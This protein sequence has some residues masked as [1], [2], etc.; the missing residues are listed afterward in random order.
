MTTNLRRIALTLTI[1]SPLAIAIA[2][3]SAADEAARENNSNECRNVPSYSELKEALTAARLQPN[4]GFD[5]DMWG[6]VVT[7]TDSCAPSR[8]QART[9][10]LNGLAAA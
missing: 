1:L 3:A 8:S 7:G 5:L 9:A 10:V 6:T 2:N 4:G